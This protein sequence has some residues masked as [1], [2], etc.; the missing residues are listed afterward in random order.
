MVVE[1]ANDFFLDMPDLERVCM[2]WVERETA[3][4]SGFAR[5]GETVK[6]F[7]EEKVAGWVVFKVAGWVGLGLREGRVE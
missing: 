5:A 1:V 4:F 2:G 6:I 7:G 3:G